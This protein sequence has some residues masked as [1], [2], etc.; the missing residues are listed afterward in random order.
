MK[1]VCFLTIEKQYITG[2]FSL[3]LDAVVRRPVD[4][5]GVDGTDCPGVDGTDCPG[6]DGTD[7]ID[8]ID[9]IDFCKHNTKV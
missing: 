8:G 3:S 5:P 2:T 7:W 4:C 1:L 9:G 6:V